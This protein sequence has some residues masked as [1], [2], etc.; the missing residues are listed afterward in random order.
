MTRTLRYGVADYSHT[1]QDRGFGPGW[2]VDRSSDCTTVRA[3]RSRVPL[4][5]QTGVAELVA[6]LA[7][8]TERRGYALRAGQ[9][10]GFNNRPIAGTD[11]PSN[12]SWGLAV[13]LNWQSNPMTWDG[14]VHTDMPSWVPDL[15]AQYGFG[16]GGDY[17]GAE[18]DAMH[19]E[20]L[21]TPASART[22]LAGARRE[23]LHVKTITTGG[24]LPATDLEAWIVSNEQIVDALIAKHTAP[25][26][27]QLNTLIKRAYLTQQALAYPHTKASLWPPMPTGADTVVGR[28]NG[29]QVNIIK[30]LKPLAA[31][32][33]HANRKVK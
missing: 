16:W 27:A 2:P 24:P 9:C 31:A 32:V 20:F 6:I 29:T 23:L 7:D 25:L 1:A 26:Q 33:A 18:R 30:A 12:H 28:I 3:A 19:L 10:G 13:D 8:E 14:Q 5:V 21:G 17:T 22:A 4:T 15:W 11:R